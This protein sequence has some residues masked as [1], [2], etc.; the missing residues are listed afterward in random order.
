MSNSVPAV[1]AATATT[2]ASAGANP[3]PKAAKSSTPQDTVS[4]SPAAKQALAKASKSHDV[5]HDGDS[6]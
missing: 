1:H 3:A 2:Q 6:H 4:I 5:D